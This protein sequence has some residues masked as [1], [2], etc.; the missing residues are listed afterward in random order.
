MTL[1]E[2][3]QDL[4]FGWRTLRKSPGF[5]SVALATLA[6]GI[7]ANS[8]IFSFVDAV[9]LKPLPYSEPDRIVMVLEKPPGGDHNG[10]ST[11]NYLDWANQNAVFEYMAAQTGGSVTLTG[12]EEPVQLNGMRVSADYF[13]V[14]GVNAAL[15]RT[16]ARGEDEEGHNN[17][18]VLSHAFWQNQFGGDPAVVGRTLLLDGKPT[19]VIGILPKGSAF[20]R[21]WPQIWRPLA[22][23][24]ENRT[25]N[26]HWMG[27][28][29]KLKPGV[30]L[31][32]ARANMDTIGGRIAK[33]FPESNKGW[34]VAVDPLVDMIVGK[35]LK[36]SL[37]VLLAAVGMVLLIGCA[38]LA[39][40]MLARG[41]A[42][43]REV[44]IRAALGA[45]RGRLI[46]QF[47]TESVLLST[48]GGVLGLALGYG[49]MTG[50][51]HILP[52]YSL[53]S[54]ANVTMDARVLLFT[55]AIALLTGIICGI[56][57]AV[58]STRPDLVTG[59]KQAGSGASA[60][61]SRHRI[62]TTLV[63]TEVAL[64]F[65]LLT[66]A[67]LLLRSF[68]RLQDVDTGFTA[69]N[70]LTMHLPLPQQ[71]FTNPESMLNY[72]REV[73]RGIETLPGVREVAFTSALPMQGWGYGMP[74]QRA[75]QPVVDPANRKACFFKM[76]SPS[77]FAAIGLRMLKGRALNEQ[78]TKGA[79]PVCVISDTMRK[80]YFGND[81]PVGKRLLVEEIAFNKTE[82]GHE[83]PWE[84]VGV[85]AD[86]KLG[87][88]NDKDGSPG[89]YVPLEQS[90]QLFLSI[91]VRSDS[92]PALLHQPIRAAVKKI[93]PDQSLPEMK[94]LAQ[95]KTESLGSS[96]LNTLL[97]GVFATLALLLAAI[98]I[99]G[100]I[101]YSVVQ[102]TREMGIRAA[103]GA[104]SGD[105][106][107]LVLGHGMSAVVVGLVIGTGAVFGL[108]RLITS[109]LF[110]V[111]EHD[112]ATL[113]SVGLILAFVALVACYLPARR[114]T[115]VNPVIALREE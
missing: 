44:A 93:N 99:Y 57:P 85:V 71:R 49:L 6:L 78:D 83:I 68:A 84:I 87:A 56:I 94:S 19:T 73:R 31:E 11:L 4:R 108:T 38:N 32:Q 98:G 95:I 54:E 100:V 1:R 14:F 3:V 113:V 59:M 70:V 105:I 47:L 34:G 33:D 17:V 96:R 74:F 79:P 114:A 90:P 12:V 30:T 37:W 46:R 89:M 63:I 23:A 107:Q 29:A 109:L 36:K 86:E 24:P 51:K 58:Q 13:R 40:L 22:F 69:T 75:D 82:L 15:G 88:L 64:A 66:G 16:F 112:P 61:R 48:I 18:V 39:N 106:L 8:A 50:L 42:R 43:D 5:T 45:G 27:A 104:T 67:G 21:G 81:D 26:F 77:Y 28:V 20:D 7:G 76:I 80:K 55:L 25:R 35:E 110:G 10:I 65:V 62:R 97:L 92:E 102:R 53:P 103:L 9:M 72:L 60:S 91:L 111:G 2:L 41:M 52:Q 115:K 101:S